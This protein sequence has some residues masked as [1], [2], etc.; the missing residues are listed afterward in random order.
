MKNYHKY[1][2]FVYMFFMTSF[3]SIAQKKI[4]YTSEVHKNH[5]NEIVFMSK[6]LGPNEV[7]EA[8]LKSEFTLGENIVSRTYLD[9]RMENVIATAKKKNVKSNGDYKWEFVSSASLAF[10]VNGTK[11]KKFVTNTL[12]EDDWTTCRSRLYLEGSKLNKGQLTEDVIPFLYAIMDY[13]KTGKNEVSAD[14][15]INPAFTEYLFFKEEVV[16]PHEILSFATGSFIINV[17]ENF[18]YFDLVEKTGYL[19]R[20]EPLAQDENVLA[21]TNKF[22]AD[23]AYFDN[24]IHYG[25]YLTD[26]N[27]TQVVH[28][29][30]GVPLHIENKYL[31]LF[32]IPIEHLE[33]NDWI[34]EKNGLRFIR[35]EGI[36]EAYVMITLLIKRPALNG[37]GYGASTFY[38]INRNV[39]KEIVIYDQIPVKLAEDFKVKLQENGLFEERVLTK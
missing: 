24:I 25:G 11:I 2:C 22:I 36:N 35:R 39:V 14:F 19:K 13:L 31:G 37:G 18:S 29:T 21:E 5:P 15:V 6:D 9:Q 20:I 1:Y 38:S 28:P 34:L 8:Y 27:W 12:L 26:P 10:T 7:K 16:N 4:D 3:L 33:D 17:P 32:K 30:T 23:N